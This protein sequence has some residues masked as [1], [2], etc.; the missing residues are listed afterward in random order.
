MDPGPPKSTSQPVPLNGPTDTAST[1]G[2]L[3]EPLGGSSATGDPLLAPPQQPG[4]LGRLGHYRVLGELGRGGM[5]AVYRA[6]DPHLQRPVALKV[7]LPHVAADPKAKA[8]FVREA[9]AQAKVEHD[10]IITIHAVEEANG[11]AF[12]VMPL[13]KGVSLAQA[14]T[15]RPRPPLPALVRIGK[16]IA[17]GL[18]AAHA[19]GLI[20]RDIKPANVWLE[21]DKRRVKILD[22][23]VARSTAV[24]AGEAQTASGAMVGSPAYMSPEQARGLKVDPRADLFSLGVVLYEMA[25]GQRPFTG[26]SV[27][28]VLSAVVT[29]RPPP[30][31]ALH[32]DIP[33]PLSDLIDRLLAKDPAQRPDGAKAVARELDAIGRT[34]AAAPP[35]QV[36]VLNGV[37]AEPNP[38]AELDATQPEEPD[39]DATVIDDPPEVTRHPPRPPTTAWVWPAAAAGA[40]GLLLLA[41]LLVAQPWK[42]KA[43]V[44]VT[45]PTAPTPVLKTNP[46]KPPATTT[47][48]KPQAQTEPKSLQPYSQPPVPPPAAGPVSR[49]DDR[50]AVEWLLA[51]AADGDTEIR[52]RQDGKVTTYYDGG[53]LS[54]GPLELIHV[55]LNR[56]PKVADADLARL[57]GCADI[58]YLSLAGNNITDAGLAH[59]RGLTALQKLNLRFTRVSGAGLPHLKDSAKLTSAEL[60]G[61]VLGDGVAALAE[62]FPA[63]AYAQVTKRG[64]TA[65][66]EARFRQV[67]PACTL[68]TADIMRPNHGLAFDGKASFVE[69]PGL[70]FDGKLPLTIEAW[71]TPETLTTAERHVFLFGPPGGGIGVSERA[72]GAGLNVGNNMWMPAYTRVG[73]KPGETVHLAAVLT[74]RRYTLYINGREADWKDVS[75]GELPATAPPAVIGKPLSKASEGYFHGT[76]HGVRVSRAARYDREFL[77]PIPWAWLP[78]DKTLALFD[79]KDVEGDRLTDRS[80]NGRHGVINGARVAPK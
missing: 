60:D 27:F 71:V 24:P 32:P 5:G 39:A 61:V 68:E 4:E 62:T 10:H 20:H 67:R 45:P 66:G 9:Q 79:C 16:E 25:A 33:P 53:K 23:G 12:I 54:P 11:V 28:D 40:V 74:G 36:V 69:V 6:E 65:A 64:I 7:L 18:A 43:R 57:T 41:G 78:D 63:L 3:V 72:F 49:G 15:V 37:T 80:G 13:L 30:V 76:I 50:K 47:E 55:A 22:F 56:N 2:T 29:H 75:L 58:E 17:D 1:R 77:P 70:K 44:E 38:W 35:P 26:P 21:G 34:L 42:S 51:V 59:L 8:R 19:A 48:T 46:A 31:A 73:I 14:L 52:V